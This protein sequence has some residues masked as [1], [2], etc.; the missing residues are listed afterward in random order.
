MAFNEKLAD[1][2]REFLVNVP[3]IEEKNM[4]GGLCFMINEK[5]CLGVFQ[6]EMLCRIDPVL[7]AEVLELIGCRPMDS[8][9]K[10]MKGFVFVSDEAM[11]TR[12]EFE[13]WISLCL[14]FNPRAKVSKK[15]KPHI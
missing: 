13:Y 2:L 10:S 1:R 5:I 3:N 9:G 4:F 8:S 11:K 14:D 6:D 15:K 12:K 7:D